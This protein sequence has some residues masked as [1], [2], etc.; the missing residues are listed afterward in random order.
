MG[1]E[2]TLVAETPS[3]TAGPKSGTHT[4]TSTLGTTTFP[5]PFTEQWAV[6]GT[7]T[8]ETNGGSFTAAVI[9]AS[10]YIFRAILPGDAFNRRFHLE[11]Q[12]VDGTGRFNKLTGTITINSVATMCGLPA[13][14][15]PPECPSGSAG[16]FLRLAVYCPEC[17]RPAFG[18]AAKKHSGRG[19]AQQSRTSSGEN[20]RK[21]QQLPPGPGQDGHEGRL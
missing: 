14:D 20:Q 19:S 8:L 11:L 9:A 7:F 6:T 18:A 12:V 1:T 4:S 5:N 21:D 17:H 3:G 13:F 16:R 10:S 2:R 15:D